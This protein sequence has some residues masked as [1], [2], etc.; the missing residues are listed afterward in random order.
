MLSALFFIGPNL[1]LFDWLMSPE[2]LCQSIFCTAGGQSWC[3]CSVSVAYPIA[4]GEDG[5]P[6][7]MDTN[8]MNWFLT[9]I[10]Q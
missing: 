2:L 9:R 1:W 10:S 6:E 3:V 5:I 8:T 4:T 7:N